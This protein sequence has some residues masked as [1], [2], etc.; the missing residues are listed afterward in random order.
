[1]DGIIKINCSNCD[2]YLGDI[3]MPPEVIL[4]KIMIGVMC[5]DC[6][7]GILKMSSEKT[8]LDKEFSKLL[9]SSGYKF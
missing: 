3:E 9:K 8:K 7:Q 2:K 4:A 1:M 6:Y 5:F